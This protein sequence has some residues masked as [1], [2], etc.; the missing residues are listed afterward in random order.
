L[1]FFSDSTP[2]LGGGQFPDDDPH[3]LF[4]MLTPNK[5]D[6]K[7]LQGDNFLSTHLL[8]LTIQCAGTRPDKYGDPFVPLLGRLGA[9]AYITSVN[10]TAL[11]ERAQARTAEEWRQNQ[12]SLTKL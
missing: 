8:D 11:L 5:D 12:A 10:L 4:Y 6:V 1:V 9:E 2:V 7:A 3:F